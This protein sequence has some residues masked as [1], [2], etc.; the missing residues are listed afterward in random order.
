MKC[1]CTTTEIFRHLLD[2]GAVAHEKW[3]SSQYV[4][5]TPNGLVNETDQVTAH[6][7]V[8]PNEWHPSVIKVPQVVEFELDCADVFMSV[9][10]ASSSPSHSKHLRGKRWKIICT[11]IQDDK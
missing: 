3:H 1:F 9:A 5:L 8:R 4:R 10:V 11:E 6:S 7:F 2:G